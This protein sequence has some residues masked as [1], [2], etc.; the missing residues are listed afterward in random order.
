MGVILGLNCKA[1]R[2]TGGTWASPT[3]TLIDNIRDAATNLEKGEADITTRG[4]GGFRQKVGTLKE[5]GIEFQMVWDTGD[6]DFAA[7]KDAYFN[8]TDIVC[9]FSDLAAGTLNAQGLKAHFSVLNFTRNEQ[10]ENAVL[11]DVKL[12]PTFFSGEQPTWFVDPGP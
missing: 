1:Y 5:G 2:K 9:W 8:D 11:V 7:F 4:G 10:L 3:W 6:A 12:S